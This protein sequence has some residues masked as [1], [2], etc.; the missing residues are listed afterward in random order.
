MKDVKLCLKS[1]SCHDHDAM[2]SISNTWAIRK[3]D[4]ACHFSCED[5]FILALLLNWLSGGS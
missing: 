5:F 1:A 4:V 2:P 3:E